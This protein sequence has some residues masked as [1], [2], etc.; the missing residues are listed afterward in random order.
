MLLV[1]ERADLIIEPSPKPQSSFGISSINCNLEFKYLCFAPIN[2]FAD[3]VVFVAAHI[4]LVEWDLTAENSLSKMLLKSI[5]FCKY[6]NV[7]YMATVW[8]SKYLRGF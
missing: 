1:W 3:L 8:Y 6:F 4:F 7:P 5:T 2:L